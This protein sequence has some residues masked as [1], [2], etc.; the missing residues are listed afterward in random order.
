MESAR[1]LAEQTPATRNRAVDFFRAMAVVMVVLGHWLVAAPYYVEGNLEPARIL[2][3]QPWTRFLTWLFQVMPVFFMVGGYSNAAS[4]ISACRE[5]EKRR[6]WQAIRMKRL[7]VPILPLVV[8]WVLAAAVARKAG[9]DPDLARVATRGGLVPVWFLAVYVL[10]TVLVPVSFR[11]WKWCGLYSVAALATAAALVDLVGFSAGMDW[12]RWANYG[13]VWLAAHQLGYWWHEGDF[14]TRGPLFLLAF[15]VASLALLTGFLGYPVSM[16]SVPGVE[17]SNSS[18]PTFAMLSIGSVEAGIMLL[19]A[20]PVSRRLLDPR[21]WRLVILASHRIMTVYL[22]HTT[23]LVALVGLAMLFDGLGLEWPPGSMA[24]WLA[25]PVWIAALVFAIGPVIV[26][27]GRIEEVARQSKGVAPG[28]V[29]A[30][31]GAVLACFGLAFLALQ[32]AGADN[33]LG[34]NIIPA[35]AAILGVAVAAKSGRAPET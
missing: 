13:F 2:T 33:S 8:F 28:P 27:V 34:V 7:L 25:R 18:P 21:P 26:L 12:L 32:G 24:W 30:F 23:V 14:Q 3:V 29:R 22:W 19:A 5:N 11:V 20:R 4:W 16:V 31:A 17:V 9:V 35:L 1:K 6:S 15:G 10:V